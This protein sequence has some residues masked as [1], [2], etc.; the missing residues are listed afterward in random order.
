[1]MV[2]ASFACETTGENSPPGFAMNAQLSAYSLK[3]I[4]EG[5]VLKPAYDKAAKELYYQA[6]NNHNLEAAVQIAQLM[7]NHL[8][9]RIA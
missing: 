8:F 9:S 7:K 4:R 1:M 6:T 3:D 5:G 2:L